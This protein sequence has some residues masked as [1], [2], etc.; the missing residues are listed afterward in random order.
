MD[1]WLTHNNFAKVIALFL[2]I[3]LWAM[4]HLDSGTPVDSTKLA[5]PRIID[6]VKIEVTGFDED[7]YVLYDLE[8]D[9]VRME[10]KGRRI[11]LTTNFSDY[12]VRLNLDNV[13][14]GTFTLPLTHE[15]P[16]GVQL[17]SMDPSIVK[18]TI[19]A[20][21]TRTLPVSIVVKGEPDDG[22]VAGIPIVAGDGNVDVTLPVSEVEEL[23][24][25]Q[26]VVDVSGLTDSVKGKSV[27]LTAYDKQGDPIENAEISPASIE[28]D[29]PINKL[30]KNVPLEV[31]HTGSLPHGYMLEGIETDVEG[32]ALYGPKEALESITSYPVTVDLSRFDG[33]P[34][35]AQFS[36]DLTPPEGFEKIEPGSVTITLVVKPAAEQQ[37]E[38][39]PVS[40]LNLNPLYDVKWVRPA[41]RKLTLTLSGTLEALEK[42]KLEDIHLMADLSPLGVGTH[43]IPVEVTLPAHVKMSDPSLNLTV[44]VELTEKGSPTTG[45]PE[46]TPDSS[47]NGQH[48][49]EN[50][51]PDSEENQ[52]HE[53][54]PVPD[55]A[56]PSG[57]E[58]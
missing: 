45:V 57:N 11:D 35:G 1:K 15:L 27:K 51:P 34:D 31:L 22:M 8:P 39:V 9:S 14:P 40:L 10:V 4:V 19:E 2:S 44:E 3:I 18:V 12:K 13:G 20:K 47:T 52:D 58:T 17:V 43:T 24:K 46:D 50:E 30:Y 42:L 41:D 53:Q 54:E 36:V 56:S 55:N 37:I 21:E 33:S 23:S 48:S 28:V 26:G 32:V 6:N 25:V 16:P 38:G 29:V 7:K 49:S 5:Q